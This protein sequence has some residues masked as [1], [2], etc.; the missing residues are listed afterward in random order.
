MRILRKHG[1]VH[2]WFAFEIRHWQVFLF[3]PYVSKG[4]PWLQWYAKW[5]SNTDGSRWWCHRLFSLR[6]L[7][8]A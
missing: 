1:F 7:K 6:L 3:P 8:K 2:A 4:E 5:T